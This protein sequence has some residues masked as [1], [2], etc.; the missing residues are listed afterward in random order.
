MTT[1]SE[2]AHLEVPVDVVVGVFDHVGAVAC[3]EW[4]PTLQVMTEED[5]K[6]F[7]E[8]LVPAPRPAN[9]SPRGLQ[10]KPKP[11]LREMTMD[12]E[13]MQRLYARRRTL[14]S[15]IESLKAQ[16][17]SANAVTTEV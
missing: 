1:G 13:T 11:Q 14:I 6:A 9:R 3:D 15:R 8:T 5:R 12:G 10:R 2:V 17:I 4:L 7:I 16:Q